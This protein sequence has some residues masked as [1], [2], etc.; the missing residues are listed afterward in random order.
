MNCRSHRLFCKN[1][2]L[3]NT[4]LIRQKRGAWRSLNRASRC[5]RGPWSRRRKTFTSLRPLLTRCRSLRAKTYSRLGMLVWCRML[6]VRTADLR[7]RAKKCHSRQPNLWRAKVN[8]RSLLPNLS[9]NRIGAG[10]QVPQKLRVSNK[11]STESL[12][13][14][15]VKEQI[16]TLQYSNK[17][18]SK[19]LRKKNRKD[20]WKHKQP[21]DQCLWKFFLRK[22]LNK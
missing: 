16:S 10:Y 5:L 8:T 19:I 6:R 14:K 4:K 11:P 2:R 12:S 17:T 13:F 1:T 22:N 18:P 7:L 15:C 21:K 20:L 3:M 9:T